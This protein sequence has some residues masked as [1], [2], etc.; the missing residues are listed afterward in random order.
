MLK[1]L[2]IQN[3][4]LI[5]EIKVNFPGKL[6]V[7]TGETGAGKS[8]LL[9]ALGLILGERADSHVLHDKS[10]KCIIEGNFLVKSYGLKNFFEENELDYG[11]EVI[12]RR[13]VTAE[14]KSRAFVND[15]PVTLQLL[16]QL[17]ARLIDIHSQHETLLL[18]ETTFRFNVVDSF[19]GILKEKEEYKKFHA[20]YRKKERQLAELKAKEAQAKKD[21]DY[22]SFQLKELNEANIVSGEMKNLESEAQTLENAELIKA[23]LSNA[24]DAINSGDTNILSAISSVKNL[25]TQ[26]SKYGNEYE[27]FLKR[28][29]SVL[30]E[31]KE[32]AN[33]LSYSGDKVVH[34][35]AR[36]EEVNEKL[37]RLNRLIKKHG[38]AGEDELAALKVEI[39][40]KLHSAGSVETDIEQLEKEL[41]GESAKLMK[42]AAFISEKRKATIPQIEKKVGEL[43]S[44]LSMPNAQF[45][46]DIATSEQLSANGIDEL[47]FLFSAN[48]GAEFRELHKVASGGELSRLMLCL[49]AI[50]SRLLSLPAII[51]DEIDSGVSG[52]VGAKIGVILDEM[53]KDMQVVTITHLPQIASQGKHHLFVYKQD[54]N[55]KTVSFIKELNDSD[56]VTEI[57]KMLST[58]KATDAAVKNAKEL[59]KAAG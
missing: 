5:E 45:K 20:Q 26:I 25:I 29:N 39:E 50:I 32:L 21:L 37:D 51:F 38:V 34:D 49:K 53:S 40:N 16:K 36:L 27:D 15:T 4:A 22:Y 3:Y 55:N 24:A 17:G 10:R 56:R 43:L 19:A 23:N 59:L 57:A 2:Y 44:R 41:K 33:D 13:E 14:G 11:D 12:I 54:I 48:K 31:L 8:I 58:G 42:Q 35:A 18:N 6:T 1:Q 9:G 47:N 46:I 28:V 7:I 30:I 52:E